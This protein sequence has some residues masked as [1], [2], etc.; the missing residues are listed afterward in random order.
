MVK[1]LE[2]EDARVWSYS[3]ITAVSAGDECFCGNSARDGWICMCELL[4][5]R[6]K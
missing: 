2:K 3:P 6:C 4:L 5:E 1:V